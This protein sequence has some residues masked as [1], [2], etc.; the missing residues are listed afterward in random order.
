MKVGNKNIV[1]RQDKTL[2]I[3]SDGRKKFHRHRPMSVKRFPL[4]GL[5]FFVIIFTTTKTVDIVTK[6]DF[7]RATACNATHSISKTFLSV[8]PSVCQTRGLWQNERNFCPHYYTAWKVIQFTG[9]KNGWWAQP[10]L[11][12]ILGQTGLVGAKTPIFNRYSLVAPII[13]RNI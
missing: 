1:V 11:A 8:R 13:S 4:R 7:Y 9:K 5:D 10:I 2:R 6:I 3:Y 12:E